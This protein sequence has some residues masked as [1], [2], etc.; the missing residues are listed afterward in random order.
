MSAPPESSRAATGLVA[1]LVRRPVWTIGL[2]ALAVSV[3]VF[4]ATLG[5][6]FLSDDFGYVG[7]FYAYPLARWPRLFVESWAGDMWGFQLRE[8]RPM[9][10]LTFIV[11]ARLWGGN[12]MGYRVT[13]L[14]L[15]VAC[16]AMV[17]WLAWRAARR[18]LACG[19]GAAVLFALHPTHPEAVQWIIGRVDVLATTFYLAGV[20][21]FVRQ[22]EAGGWSWGLVALLFYAAA[23]FAKE[24]GLTLPVMWL[25]ADIW[26]L[27]GWR[28][29]RSA[30]ALLPYLGAIVL[31]AIYFFCRRAA[32]GS[33]G[34]G[35]AWPGLGNVDFQ[36]Q[37]AARQLTYLGH[38]FPPLET[39]LYDGAPLL[40]AHATR[41]FLW[42]AGGVAVAFAA[43]RWGLKKI[44]VEERRAGVFFGVGWYLVATL[45]LV[46]TYISARHLY[47]ASAGACVALALIAHGLLR[48]RVFFA[49]AMIA[50][51]ASFVPGLTIA[52]KRWQIAATLSRQVAL[53]LKAVAP[54]LK[55]GGALF[56][57]VPEVHEGVNVWAWAVPFALRPPFLHTATVDHITVL[58]IRGLYV[59]WDRWHEQPAIAA[60]RNT[61]ADGWIVQLFEGKPPRRIRVPAEKIRVAAEHFA[62]EPL[63]QDPYGAWRKLINEMAPP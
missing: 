31:V 54:E 26:W 22:R 42:I 15:H 11:D 28:R 58:E 57:D 23:A 59:D 51:G 7:R 32:F 6:H 53:E 47:L 33:D 16:G 10:A 30:S 52:M 39:W 19:L 60:L 37:T 25:L 29:W 8:L 56:F 55:P 21:A 41:T 63:K 12:A 49:V 13:N 45:P 18:D 50:L 40:E 4:G 44:A 14:A 5:G 1:A 34:V 9:T 35:A 17:G 2:T 48:S 43:W 61:S 20:C 24:F 62:A 36:R 38:L 27:G 46:V 3:V